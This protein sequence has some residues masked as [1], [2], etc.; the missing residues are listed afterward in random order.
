MLYEDEKDWYR[1][2]IAENLEDIQNEEVMVL[3]NY[4]P[5]K[6]VSYYRFSKYMQTVGLVAWILRFANNCRKVQQNER[7]TDLSFGETVFAERKLL[8]IMQDIELIK[9]I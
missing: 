5:E 3:V 1:S 8:K 9:V 6:N 4:L 2:D 7:N